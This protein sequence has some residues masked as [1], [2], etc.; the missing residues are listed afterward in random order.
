[1][2]DTYKHPI[3]EQEMKDI[4]RYQYESFSY[5]EDT[6]SITPLALMEVEAILYRYFRLKRILLNSLYIITAIGIWTL[7]NYLV[8]ILFF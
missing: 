4:L 3:T 7:I 6:D 2:R 1:M 8:K 5:I